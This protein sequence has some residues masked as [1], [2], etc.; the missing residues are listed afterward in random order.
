VIGLPINLMISRLKPADAADPADAPDDQ[1][2]YGALPA[3]M[4]PRAL[5]LVMIVFSSQGLVTWG[6]QPNMVNVLVSLGLPLASAI[7]LASLH[8]PSQ[9]AGRMVDFGSRGQMSP[10]TMGLIASAL[11]PLGLLVMIYAGVS[12]VAAVIGIGLFGMAAGL[13]SII[14]ASIPLHLF[15]RES[16]GATLG[17]IALPMNI[18]CAAAPILFAALISRVGPVASLTVAAAAGLCGLAVM[19]KLSQETKAIAAP[20]AAPAE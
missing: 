15:G 7:F 9:L 14:R 4:R 11:A 17:R 1:E 2:R 6:I 10:L 20:V 13:N 18:A 5:L 16:Y 12:Q 3:R 19:I 8:G